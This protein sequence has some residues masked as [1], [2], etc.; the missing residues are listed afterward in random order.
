MLQHGRIE[1]RR[2]VGK[3]L[4][5]EAALKQEHLFG[6]AGI[7]HTRWAT[8]GRPPNKTPI[9]I[10]QG[11]SSSFTTALLKIIWPTNSDWK[12]RVSFRIRDGYRSD[13]PF[14]GISYGRG[15]IPPTGVSN[16]DLAI[17]WELRNCRYVCERPRYPGRDQIGVSFGSRAK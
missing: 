8:H 12:T 7:G 6:T 10:V 3:L 15:A 14:I 1:I 16:N 2:S 5:L 17:T 4:H 9:P 11:T 13:R